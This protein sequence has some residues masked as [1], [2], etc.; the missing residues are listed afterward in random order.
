ML[1]RFSECRAATRKRADTTRHACRIKEKLLPSVALSVKGTWPC[2]QP[3]LIYFNVFL[4]GQ[5]GLPGD[6]A[7]PG[8]PT[9]RPNW[10]RGVSDFHTGI[11]AALLGMTRGVDCFEEIPPS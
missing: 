2:P 4:S 6:I 1:Q 3:D 9:R 10:A 5:V 11:A 8:S 7:R